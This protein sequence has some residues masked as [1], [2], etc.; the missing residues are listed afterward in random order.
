MN[1]RTLLIGL[2][3]QITAQVSG[4]AW[5]PAAAALVWAVLARPRRAFTEGFVAGLLAPALLLGVAAVRGA[6]LGHFADMMGGVFQ[7]PGWGVLALSCVLPAL[8]AG[9]VAGA[10]VPMLRRNGAGTAARPSGARG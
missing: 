9:G 2:L 5:A 10:V 6:P 8:M 7:L 1:M 4:F 3:L